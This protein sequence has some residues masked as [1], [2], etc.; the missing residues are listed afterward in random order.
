MVKVDLYAFTGDQPCRASSSAWRVRN[1]D[2]H[3]RRGGGLERQLRDVAGVLK[4]K[5]GSLD[6]TYLRH[7]A[8]TLDVADLLDDALEG[9]E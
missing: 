4:T 2:W 8:T 7:A 9:A 1:L 3:R 5:R 6:L